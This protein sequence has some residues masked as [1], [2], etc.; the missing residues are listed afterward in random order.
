MYID[1]CLSKVKTNV[2]HVLFITERYKEIWD[3]TS[4]NVLLFLIFV[5]VF[6]IWS[7]FSLFFSSFFFLLWSF[8]ILFLV[9]HVHFLDHSLQ[10][11]VFFLVHVLPL[12]Q[13][14][15][16]FWWYY[17]SHRVR[18]LHFVLV[19]FLLVP[20]PVQ[21]LFCCS[22]AAFLSHPSFILALFVLDLP[23]CFPQRR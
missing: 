21:L 8:S 10:L 23:P 22:S 2:C 9:F 15:V 5:F 17:C 20:V 18:L 16:L 11:I 19:F 12:V 14:H 4:G 13:A 7:F 1:K 3:F 6:L